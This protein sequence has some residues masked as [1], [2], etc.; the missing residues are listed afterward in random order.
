MSKILVILA[1]Y[2]LGFGIAFADIK[3]LIWRDNKNKNK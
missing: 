3:Y 1:I 2:A